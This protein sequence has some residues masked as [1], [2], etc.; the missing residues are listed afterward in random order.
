MEIK[1]DLYLN[2]LIVRKQNGFIKVITGVRRCGKSYLLNTLF[3]KHL[4]AEG[5]DD[6]H[7]IKFAFD[8]A[9]DLRLIG[10][11]LFEIDEENRKVDPAKFMDYINTRVTDKGMYYLLLDEVQKL[12]S[13][14]SVLN[15]YLRKNNMD[16][17]VTGSNSK[18]LSSDIIT[19]FEGRGDEVHVLPLSFSE[20]FSAYDGSK[21]EA[22]DD[23]MVYG[24]LPAVA[25]MKTEEQK[26][27]YLMTQIRNL[28]LRDIVK[29]YKLHSDED[30]GELLDILASGI[31]TLVNPKKLSDTFK[32]VKNSG[33]CAT[34]VAKYISHLEDAFLI[35]KVRRFDVKGKRYIDTPYKV[36]FEDIG[37][38]N[39]RLN[40]RQIEPTHLMENI[41]FNELRYRG[42]NVDVGVVES[43]ER[44]KDGK[45]I[46]KQLE[47]DFIANQGSRRYYIQSAYE[48]PSDSKWEQETRSFDKTNDSFKKIIIV[49]R[50]MKPRRNDKGYVT[51]GVKEFLLN[52]NS[53]EM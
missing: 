7:I 40:F 30:I 28:Y 37:L 2:K 31:S 27:N 1:R 32:S 44:D 3:Y 50:S 18:F 12:G 35:S 34:T 36:Y 17:F 26:T 53:L 33:I 14:E 39:A 10:E 51:M 25:L 21:D 8:S 13:F 6:G 47:I 22:F 46:R 16:V 23:Y 19:E 48:I 29:R 4:L 52:E 41:I 49:E 5:V 9:D 43:R 24:G 45:E 15:G 20:F 11:D 42:Y 38:R